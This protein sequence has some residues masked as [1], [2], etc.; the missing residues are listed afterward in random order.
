MKPEN[1]TFEELDVREVLIKKDSYA[2]KAISYLLRD[3]DTDEVKTKN[4]GINSKEL[5]EHA[6]EL[7][8]LAW[9]G[10]ERLFSYPSIFPPIMYGHSSDYVVLI[11]PR[12]Y[13]EYFSEE[14]SNFSTVIT[15]NFVFQEFMFQSLPWI[16]YNE[17]FLLGRDAFRI[18]KV[19]GYED[20][21]HLLKIKTNGKE[22]AYGI[23]KLVMRE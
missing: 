1:I 20:K 6:K 4:I 19:E 2:L 23:K 9:E 5:S 11:N 14:I 10:D 8:K 13:L 22:I 21:V 7:R 3:L 16:K 15:S 18:A 12:T 17:S